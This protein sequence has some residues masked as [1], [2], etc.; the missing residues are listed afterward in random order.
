MRTREKEKSL[1]VLIGEADKAFA[2]FIKLRDSVNG[3]VKCFTCGTKIPKSIAQCAHYIDRD[4]MPVRFHEQNAHGCC[5]EC[6]CYDTDH[7]A[8][9][10]KAMVLKYGI[11]FVQALE[12]E[13][14]GLQKFMRYEVEELITIYKSKVSELKKV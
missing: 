11:G 9:Y 3:M 14:R 1:S 8:K 4:Q 10:A 7:K 5:Q 6:N 13:S 2:D 12:K